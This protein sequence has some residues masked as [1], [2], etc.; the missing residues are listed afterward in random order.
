MSTTTTRMM[1]IKKLVDFPP[2]RFTYFKQKP[3]SKYNLVVCE[4]R[5]VICDIPFPCSDFIVS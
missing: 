1:Q 5:E 3:G 4:F 2:L